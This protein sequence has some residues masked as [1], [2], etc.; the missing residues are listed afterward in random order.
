[1]STHG[2]NGYFSI[3]DSGATVLRNLSPY[4]NSIEPSWS[5]DIHD[6]TTFGQT[7]H[8]KRGG[9]TDGSIN[10]SGMWDK[11]TDV[12]T[13]TVLRSLLGTQAPVNWEYGPEGNASG[14]V[15]ES[16]LG[17]LESYAESVPVADLITFT[18]TI[19]VSGA[20]TDGTWSA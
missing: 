13:Y 8:T 12:G 14:K 2:M 9:L 10:I 3:E 15:K 11:T 7:G 19:Q 4:L 17:V 6:D 5:N 18:A 1:M 16:G 20:I